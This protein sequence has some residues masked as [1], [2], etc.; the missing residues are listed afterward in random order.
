MCLKSG[1]WHVGLKC[2]PERFGEEVEV[3]TAVKRNGHLHLTSLAQLI[4]PLDQRDIEQ[5]RHTSA[6]EQKV[7]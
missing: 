4:C 2:L 7:C 3:F 1:T 5:I 6:A